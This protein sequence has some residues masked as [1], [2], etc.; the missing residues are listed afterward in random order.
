M[1]QSCT[2]TVP[3]KRYV[4]SRSPYQSR[5]PVAYMASISPPIR[6]ELIFCPA[7]KRPC[8][9]AAPPLMKRPGAPLSQRA[10]SPSKRSISRA[11]RAS[12]RRLP[13]SVSRA[14]PATRAMALQRCQAFAV[15]RSRMPSNADTLR[16][17][18][19]NSITKNVEASSQCAARSVR[20]K[21]PIRLRRH[22][23]STCRPRRRRR[24]RAAPS[25]RERESRRSAARAPT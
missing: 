9:G 1:P 22:S 3:A 11:L 8:G 7:L 18:P 2:I 5:N 16:H 24:S 19:V 6:A 17:R 10:S 25:S 14:S 21:R 4:V 12:A 23:R 20:V 13:S 15:G